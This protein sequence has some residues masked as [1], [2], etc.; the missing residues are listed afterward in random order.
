[1]AVGYKRRG[2]L[3]RSYSFPFPNGSYYGRA[4]SVGRRLELG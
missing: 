4:V 1:L 3:E 2:V